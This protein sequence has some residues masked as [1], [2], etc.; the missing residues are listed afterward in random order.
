MLQFNTEG[1]TDMLTIDNRQ[2][3]DGRPT[4]VIAEIGINYNGSYDIAAQLV[5]VAAECGVDA[6]KLQIITAEKSYTPDSISHSIF[7]RNELCLEE[8]GALVKLAR[9]LGLTVFA[10]FVNAYDL[11]YAESI[12]LPAVKISSTNITNFPLLEAI[13]GL[14]KPVIM[15]TGMAYLNE[16]D[17]AVRYL[18]DRGLR[19]LGILH[20]S[21]L[22]PATP[23]SLNLRAIQ[24]LKM[25][26][27]DYPIGFSDHTLGIHCAVAAVVCGASIIEK[28]FTL[29]RDMDGPDHHFSATPAEMKALMIAIREVEAALGSTHKRPVAE[30]IP[31]RK[32]FQRSLVAIEAIRKGQPIEAGMLIPKRS[33]V[34]GVEPKYLDI[35]CGRT[36][37]ADIPQDAPITWDLI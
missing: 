8:W 18:E 36:A 28:H 3:G 27:P 35:I 13:A 33:P 25:A 11:Q 17:E 22:Y 32:E 7:K 19:E 9:K 20:C 26:Y 1:Q 24:T 4:Y 37:R 10:T 21:S 14:E 12:E 15:S 29:D 6:V 30:E 31:I 2:I 16:V 23:E 34:K 5:T